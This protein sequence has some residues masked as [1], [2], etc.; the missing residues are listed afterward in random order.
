[1]AYVRVGPYNMTLLSDPTDVKHVLQDEPDRYGK[2]LSVTQ[3]LLGDGIS[4]AEGARWRRHRMQLKTSFSHQELSR[5]FPLALA[6]AQRAIEQLQVWDRR[7]MDLETTAVAITQG[8]IFTA[9][10]GRDYRGDRQTFLRAFDDLV[11]HQVWLALLPACMVNWPTPWAVAFH[12]AMAR[13]NRFVMD[14]ITMRDRQ[15]VSG[16]SIL[17]QL[18]G[19]RDADDNL[20]FSE[21][22]VRDDIVSLMLAGYETT[23]ATLC[24]LLTLVS[25]H[26]TTYERLC[27]ESRELVTADTVTYADLG[28]FRYGRAV[29]DEV[30]RLYPPGWSMRRIALHADR[31]PCGVS[32]QPH[33]FILISPFI[34]H[35]HP[36]HWQH[37]DMFHPHRFL[38]RDSIRRRDYAFMPFGGGPRRCLGMNFA[39]MELLTILLVLLKTGGWHVTAPALIPIHSRGT[40]KPGIP[41][42][43]QWQA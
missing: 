12:R 14:Q 26:P 36:Q 27:R 2:H 23:A 37:P 41:L 42:T 6:N 13:I 8:V 3:K 35:R 4:N 24:W 11:S 38:D 9:L 16:D 5:Y 40:M 22:D 34:L 31:L 15:A 39:Y 29:I 43:L 20:L 17:D 19:A 32:I 1:M 25:Q 21:Q 28:R 7:G 33:D 10:F 30:L 18:L